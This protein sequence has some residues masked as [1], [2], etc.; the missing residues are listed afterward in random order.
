[1]S[2]INIKELAELITTEINQNQTLSVA[3]AYLPT[4]DISAAASCCENHCPCNSK[5]TGGPCSCQGICG[6]NGRTASK[7]QNIRNNILDKENL[8]KIIDVA[9]IITKLRG[10][11]C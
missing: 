1:M 3:G 8:Q 2:V 11:T 5:G 4:Y 10:V 6:C 7:P 9:P